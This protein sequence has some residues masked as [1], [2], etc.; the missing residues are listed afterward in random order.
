M[1]GAGTQEVG[2]ADQELGAATLEEM[3]TQV[4]GAADQQLGAASLEEA[5]RE[6]AP[7]E[8][9]PE[10]RSSPGY[11]SRSAF[12]AAGQSDPSIP[13]QCRQFP[14]HILRC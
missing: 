12:L 14:T 1:V 6:G 10:L 3:G 7:E 2:A 13:F 8:S 5:D 9:A 11:R 4:V